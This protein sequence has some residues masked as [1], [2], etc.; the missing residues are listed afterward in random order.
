M[1]YHS[2]DQATLERQSKID[3]GSAESS[4]NRPHRRIEGVLGGLGCK[5]HLS[6]GFELLELRVTFSCAAG[7][8]AKT[9]LNKSLPV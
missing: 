3:D 7:S 5:E 6:A 8:A 9:V 1:A 4:C 2:A